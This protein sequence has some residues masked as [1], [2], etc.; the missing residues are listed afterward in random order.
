[1]LILGKISIQ[2]NVLIEHQADIA[3]GDFEKFSEVNDVIIVE[4]LVQGEIKDKPEIEIFKS[5]W[6]PPAA[7]LYARK[8]AEKINWSNTLPVIQD[9]RYLLDAVFIGG[10]LVYTP[11]VQAKYRIKQNQS[12]SQ[13][14][15]KAFVKDCFVNASEI[16]GIWKQ[17]LEDDHEKKNALIEVLRFCIHEFSIQDQPLF[18]Q[19][20]NLLLKIEP[21][22]IPEKSLSLKITSKVFGYRNAEKLAA[23]KRRL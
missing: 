17:D 9:A 21:N 11:G 12:L 19:A 5:F 20:I 15:N 18:Q 2:L 23:L 1:M 10:K 16:Y 4:E 13:R 8:I 3:Y 14:N 22:Y 7:I 6:R